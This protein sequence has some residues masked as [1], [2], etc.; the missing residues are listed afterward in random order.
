[1][2]FLRKSGSLV[3]VWIKSLATAAW[4]S[5]CSGN[6]SLRKNFAT[7]HC[8]PRS[9]VKISDTVVS[10]TPRSASS[11]HTVSHQSLLIAACTHSTFPGVLIVAGL[12]EHGSLPTGSRPSLR[13]LCHSFICAA[14]IALSPKAFWIIQIVSAE[15]CSSL[16]QNMMQ[17]HCWTHSVILNVMAT[18]YKCSLNSVYH[19]HWLVQWSHH[20]SHLCI[21]L[22]Y[23]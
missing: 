23:P 14:L 2:S 3:V 12:P 22:H 9:C 11:S 6:R 7:T 16:M 15:E 10:G 19:P 5:F 18:Q 4:C 20:C 13:L 21:S 17:I 1:M 8:M